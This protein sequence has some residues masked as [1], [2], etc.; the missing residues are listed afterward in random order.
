MKN[1]RRFLLNALLLCGV[2][3]IMRTVNVS[4][5]VYVSNAAGAEAMGLYSLLS[6]VYG[7]ALTFATSGIHIT[8]VRMISGALGRGDIARAHAALRACLGYSILFGGLAS[9]GLLFGAPFIGNYLLGDARTVLSLRCLSLT[10]VPIAITSVFNGYFTA[11]RRVWKNAVIQVSEQAIRIFSVY[12]LLSLFLPRGVEFACAALALGGAVAESASFLFSGLAI[13]F[14][15]KK[16][17]RGPKK[18][19][20]AGQVRGEMLSTALP[21]AFSAY[22]RSGLIAIEHMLIPRGLCQNGSSRGD[23]LAAYGRLHGMALPI[24][25][26]PSAFISSFAGLLVPELTECCASGNTR[27]IRYI[28]ERVTQLALIFSLGVSGIMLCFSQ[29]LAATIY[30]N[31]DTAKYIAALAPLIPIMYLDTT[32]DSMLK[33]LGEQFYCMT[34]NI[35]DSSLSVLLVWLLLPRFGITGYV[36]TIYITEFVNATLSITRL[37]TKSGM[38]PRIFK[39]VS[40]PLICIVGAT[41]LAN[42]GFRRITLATLSHPMQVTIH[43]FVTALIYIALLLLTG[44]FDREDIQWLGNIFGYGEKRD[45]GRGSKCAYKIFN[46]NEGLQ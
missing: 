26:F 14:D 3:L 15:K 19:V 5:N 37:I 21:I 42:L 8:A 10:L 30:P 44:A 36:I 32:V 24:I 11:V 39:W 27:Q 35:L 18:D 23:S 25:L 38:L 12:F 33:G 9:V 34:V 22:A 16:N 45:Q 28:C 46:K 7:F 6:G 31:A 29:E 17:L 1:I 20:A 40:K 13:L 4:F 2:S 41:C 43:I